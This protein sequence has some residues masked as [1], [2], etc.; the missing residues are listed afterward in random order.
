MTT[1]TKKTTE[2]VRLVLGRRYSDRVTGFT[3]TCTSIARYIE[4]TVRVGLDEDSSARSEWFDARRLVE[5]P[6][7]ARKAAAPAAEVTAP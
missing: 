5:A 7:A 1:T 3:G 6:R 2:A 4:G